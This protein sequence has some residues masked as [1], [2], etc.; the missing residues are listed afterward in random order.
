[1]IPPLRLMT[2]AT[3]CWRWSVNVDIFRKRHKF[4]FFF[5]NSTAVFLHILRHDISKPSTEQ[6]NEKSVLIIGKPILLLLFDRLGYPFHSVLW[7]METTQIP[8]QCTLMRKRGTWRYS[9][10]LLRQCWHNKLGF[11]RPG[12]WWCEGPDLGL[13]PK[14]LPPLIDLVC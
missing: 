3:T 10:W 9:P 7:N 1:M 5:L 2:S 13:I 12:P 14:R 4:V 6:L 11:A 8:D